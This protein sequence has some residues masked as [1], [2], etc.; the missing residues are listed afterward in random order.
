MGVAGGEPSTTGPLPLKPEPARWQPSP[1]R[2]WKP[3]EAPAVESSALMMSCVSTSSPLPEPLNVASAGQ[4]SLSPD[5]AVAMNGARK[6]NWTPAASALPSPTVRT[7]LPFVSEPAPA[8]VQGF[9]GDGSSA[10]PYSQSAP[11]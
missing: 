7:I 2:S 4:P 3:P 6:R 9:A 10:V 8:V 11:G 1:F 5:Q